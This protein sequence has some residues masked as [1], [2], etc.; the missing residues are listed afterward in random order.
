MYRSRV[1]LEKEL[2]EV[3]KKKV[4]MIADKLVDMNIYELQFFQ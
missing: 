3:Q 1:Y 2:S 4:E